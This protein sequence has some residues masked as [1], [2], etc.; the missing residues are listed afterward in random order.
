[1]AGKERYA[2]VTKEIPRQLSIHPDGQTFLMIRPGGATA[3]DLETGKPRFHLEQGLNSHVYYALFSA[4]GRW[5]FT[6]DNHG[7]VLVWH[8]KDGTRRASVGRAFAYNALAYNPRSQMLAC[9]NWNRRASLL[10]IRLE[11]PTVKQKKQMEMFLAQLDHDALEVREETSA[12]LLQ[13]GFLVDREL[14][15]ASEQ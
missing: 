11:D 2:F 4:D 10:R 1:M 12:R 7:R 15:Q 9:A 14:Q 3:I 13:L 8:A 6:S 5:V